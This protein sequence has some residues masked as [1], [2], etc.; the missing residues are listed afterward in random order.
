MGL[1][2][3]GLATASCSQSTAE[4]VPSALPGPSAPQRA[5]LEHVFLI[6]LDTL[7]AD[8]CSLYGYGKPTTPFLEELGSRGIVFESHMVSSNNTL[9]SHASIL[10]GLYPLTH[11]VEDSR[12]RREALA[13]AFRT[14]AEAFSEAGFATASFATHETWLGREYGVMQGF[15]QVEAQWI[16]SLSCWQ[17]FE[18]WF[19][20]EQPG[21]SFVFL[22]SFDVHSD[23]AH[24]NV[25]PYESSADHIARFAPPAPASFTGCLKAVPQDCASRYLRGINAGAEPLPPEHLEYLLGLYDAGIRKQDDDLR[26]LFAALEGRGLLENSLIAITSDH[27]E[28]FMEHGRLLHTGTS[29]AIMHVPLLFLL[30]EGWGVEPRRISRVT[31]SID[32]APTLLEACGLAPIGQGRS[33]WS[34]LEGEGEPPENEVL[35]AQSV[36]RSSDEHG[37][38]KLNCGANLAFYDLEADPHEQVNLYHAPGFADSPRLLA[39]RAR[40]DELRR[41]SALLR[42]EVK[43]G[44]SFLPEPRADQER[45]IEALRDLGY[46]DV[47]GEE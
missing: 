41:A 26:V 7:R 13:P 23:D 6:S 38:F 31:R 21:R 3:C 43:S 29:D 42:E 47:G 46:V 35:F 30:P 5:A 2:A 34:V 45:A 27:G 44:A 18:S 24:G 12:A 22:H 11:A 4:P 25:L 33:L 9:E 39:A 14:L 37:A 40:I 1:L 15:E 20:A 16:D 36:L 32:I 28:E 10:T 8:H 19:D 17:R